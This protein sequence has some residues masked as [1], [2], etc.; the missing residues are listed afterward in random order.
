M[1]K[2]KQRKCIELMLE[3]EKKQKEI[4]AALNISEK[5]IS[6]W[7]K[8]EEFI[9]AYDEALSSILRYASSKALRKQIKLID[10]ANVQVAHLAAKDILDRAGYKAAKEIKLDDNKLNITIS[11][12]GVFDEC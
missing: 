7:K 2:P 12:G 4:A 6:E 9:A 8:N 5:T 3:G 10:S 1:L 11:G